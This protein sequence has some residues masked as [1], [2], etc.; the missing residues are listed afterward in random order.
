MSIRQ[1]KKQQLIQM[2]IPSRR[3]NDFPATKQSNLYIAGTREQTYKKLENI[4]F[5]GNPVL[6]EKSEPVLRKELPLVQV[7]VKDLHNVME[8]S[9]L[10][11]A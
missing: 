2:A 1:L 6:Y 10:N 9:I 4:L 11:F 8:E 3:K 7:W 5:I